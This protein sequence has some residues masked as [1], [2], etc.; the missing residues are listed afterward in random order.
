L[1]VGADPYTFYCPHL[2]HGAEASALLPR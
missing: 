1:P 2:N